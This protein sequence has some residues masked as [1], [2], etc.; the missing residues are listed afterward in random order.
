M[1]ELPLILT[2]KI[3]WSR[4]GRRVV[5]VILLCIGAAAAC[6]EIIKADKV[7]MVTYQKEVATGDTIWSICSKVATDKEDVCKL[8]WQVMQDNHIENPGDLQPGTVIVIHVKK[9]REL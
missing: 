5:A 3:Y 2:R 1:N 6:C 9:A 7:P 4:K 8:T